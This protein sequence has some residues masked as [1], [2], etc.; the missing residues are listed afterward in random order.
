[1]KQET[2]W[3]NETGNLDDNLTVREN[4]TRHFKHK[5]TAPEK[6]TKSVD[7]KLTDCYS[8]FAFRASDT[9]NERRGHRE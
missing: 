9:S 5:R 1:M 6:E 8:R 3:E 2:V 7:D 4:E